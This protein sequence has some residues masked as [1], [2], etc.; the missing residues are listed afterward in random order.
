MVLCFNTSLLTLLTF[1]LPASSLDIYHYHISAY[2]FHLAMKTRFGICSSHSKTLVLHIFRI[3][4]IGTPTV[5]LKISRA[6]VV[7]GEKRGF[8][9]FAYELINLKQYL[10]PGM[11]YIEYLGV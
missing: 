2:G 4:Y 7:M 9:D 8:I 5:S 1:T 11:S 3:S 10:T 6:F